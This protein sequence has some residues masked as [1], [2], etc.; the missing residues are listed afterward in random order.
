MTVHKAKGLEYPVVITASIKDRSFPL[1]YS[2]QRNDH[3]FNNNPVYPI[4][5]RF[6]RYKISEDKEA[7]AFNR[8][9]ER[10]VMLQTPV[11]RNS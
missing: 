11:Q 9:E 6:L 7:E 3:F 8:E 2:P 1:T 5:N 4:P 10:V